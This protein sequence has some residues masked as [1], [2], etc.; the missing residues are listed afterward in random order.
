MRLFNF[1]TSHHTNCI[2]ELW[3]NLHHI[4]F[5]VIIT[6]PPHQSNSLPLGFTIPHTKVTIYLAFYLFR[7]A[8]H[9]NYFW[10]IPSVSLCIKCDSFVFNYS[11]LVIMSFGCRIFCVWKSIMIVISC[12]CK[13][14]VRLLVSKFVL[15]TWIIIAVT[16]AL[17]S[18][19][20]CE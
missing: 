1:G 8:V 18:E 17:F 4:L 6:F 9:C 5:I 10:L 11:M 12:H 16:A 13:W 14:L 20:C 19:G 7:S 3:F 15:A 2:W